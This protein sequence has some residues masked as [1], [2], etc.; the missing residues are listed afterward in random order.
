VKIH[1]GPCAGI[2]IL[3]TSLATTVVA[4]CIVE[5]SALTMADRR[6]TLATDQQALF[7]NQ[8]P[9]QGPITLEEA[10]A[11]AVKYNLDS[12][13]KMM[14]AAVAQRELDLSNFDLL[15]KLAA[16][17]GYT[18][19]DRVLAS[20]SR[21]VATG[22]ESLVPSTSTDRDVRTADLNLSW[23]VL[24]FGVSY[25][26]AKQQADRVLGLQERRRKAVQQL[27][28]QTRGAFWQAAGA[29][30]L[31]GQIEPLLAQA[32]QAL[33]DSRNIEQRRL[34]PP[35]EALAYQRE[36]LELIVQLEAVRDQLE[37]AKPKLAA[38]MDLPPGNPFEVA[39]PDSFN[40]P[41]LRIAPEQMEETALLN[42]P[43]LIEARYNERIGLNETHKAMARLLPGVQL[44]LGTHYDSNSFLVYNAWNDAGVQ[45]S[46][47]LLN[48]VSAHSI[49]ASAKAQYLLAREQRLAACIAV[50]AQV[51]VA[52]IDFHSRQEQFQLIEELNGV[53][54]R[55]L[56]HTR[57]AAAADARGKLAEIR[58]ATSAL[59][60]QLRL[61]E[62]YS[63]YQ[64][65]YGE[66]LT[67]LGVDPLPNVP[68]DADLGA[69]ATAIREQYANL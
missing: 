69:L 39:A 42:R 55:M 6:A 25:Y 32:R 41:A 27:M 54:Q 59:M 53:E 62:S 63:G 30:R 51:H 4:G 26:G 15:P 65:A 9:V 64:D 31:Q 58:A 1:S 61:Y 14:E 60:T 11:R 12:R 56:E 21:S 8:Q 24:D 3:L 23:N 52:W 48:L 10:M 16:S 17:A 67:T 50:L 43:E 28:Q 66:M 36:L 38:I 44:S 57:N 19:R 7:S 45:A 13:V 34:E 2:R 5:P 37:Q 46:W 18:R 29:Q 35:L 47:N 49:R 40:Q 20:S 33:N 22:A 68:A